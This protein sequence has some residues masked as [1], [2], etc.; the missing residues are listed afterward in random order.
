MVKNDGTT[1]GFLTRDTPE[2]SADKRGSGIVK[3]HLP[4]FTTRMTQT[5]KK[6]SKGWR[7]NCDVQLLLYDTDPR[8]PDIYEL[9]RV[10]DYVV[11]YTCKG[12]TTTE[13]EIDI[14]SSLIS[15]SSTLGT[16]D[17]LLKTKKLINCFFIE[18]NHKQARM[19]GRVP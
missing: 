18:Q 14:M 4:R 9:S 3:L 8:E 6:L 17:E 5:S 12:N 2:I 19:C 10:T 7:A 1:P 11:S 15:A 13:S 16:D